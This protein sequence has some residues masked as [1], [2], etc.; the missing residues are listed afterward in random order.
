M[1]LRHLPALERVVDEFARLPSIGRKSALRLACFLMT[2]PPERAAAIADALSALHRDTTICATCGGFG[3]Q[4]P[5]TICTDPTRDASIL[6]L[7]EDATDV[8]ALE[9]GGQFKGLYH[10]LGGKLN[11]ARG[12]TPDKLRLRQLLGRLKAGHAIR[13]IILATSP[14]VDG[15]AT[16]RLVAEEVARKDAKVA[17]TRIGVGVP[18]GGDLEYADDLTLARAMEGRRKM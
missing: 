11:P 6:C 18:I 15:E 3:A 8:L 2:A 17:V 13:E 16:A 14:G 10:V 12:V 4:S 5:C 7:V 9:R 1:N